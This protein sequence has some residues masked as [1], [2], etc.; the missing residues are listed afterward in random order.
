MTPYNDKTKN[1]K[2]DDFINFIMS[3]FTEFNCKSPIVTPK[4]GDQILNCQNNHCQSFDQVVSNFG[5]NQ[6][7]EPS[8]D[9][10]TF[11][12]V[13]STLNKEQAI[14]YLKKYVENYPNSI[15]NTTISNIEKILNYNIDQMPI[16]K[17]NIEQQQQYIDNTRQFILTYE[18][19][20]LLFKNLEKL[21]FI[22]IL[23]KNDQ[24]FT[25]IKNAKSNLDKYR[26]FYKNCLKNIKPFIKI[27]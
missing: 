16:L 9:L 11:L 26:D 17:R 24:I 20:E 22:F 23:P 21:S 19:I 6:N 27:T 14:P 12:S 8:N 1:F 13:L 10:N 15:Y 25:Y 7:I 2:I 18:Q 5:L 4:K 3:L